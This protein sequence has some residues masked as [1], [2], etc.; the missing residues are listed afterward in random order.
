MDPFVQ[1]LAVM[2]AVYCIYAFFCHA[3][4]RQKKHVPLGRVTFTFYHLPGCGWC[5]RAMPEW[6]LLAA[7]YS[8]PVALRL[9]DASRH[10]EEISELGIDKFPTFLLAAE[11][12]DDILEYKGARTQEEM[13]EFLSRAYPSAH[14]TPSPPYQPPAAAT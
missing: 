1:I 14:A 7:S 10:L 12:S 9:V 11:G 5:K 3:S 2:L 6:E 8:G 4:Y 13:E